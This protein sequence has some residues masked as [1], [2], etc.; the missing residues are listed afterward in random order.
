MEINNQ[1]QIS[2]Q[3]NKLMSLIQTLINTKS[4][5]NEREINNQ[6][7]KESEYL[8][9]LL[10][11]KENA[12]SKQININNRLYPNP[13]KFE[14]AKIKNDVSK[15]F[16]IN[17]QFYKATGITTILQCKPN[18]KVSDIINRYRVKANDFE[19][20]RFD[21]NFNNLNNKLSY[22]LI[23]C[24][25]KNCDKIVVSSLRNVVGKNL[26]NFFE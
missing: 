2:H 8:N 7:K 11:I 4:L 3:K 6:I 24:G 25:I 21:H 22:T 16:T 5:K 13:L 15:L 14:Q 26:I 18:E 23:Q 19:Q 10:D 1:N 12:L 9:S 20:N 17:V